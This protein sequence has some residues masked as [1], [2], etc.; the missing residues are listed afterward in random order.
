[1]AIGSRTAAEAA[2]MKE[3]ISTRFGSMK[4]SIPF[5]QAEM[6]RGTDYRVT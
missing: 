6:E 2:V 1:M 3:E 4:A 5:F